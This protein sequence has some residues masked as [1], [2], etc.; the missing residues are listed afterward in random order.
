METVDE[1]FLAA[2]LDFM[3]RK[4][5]A[6]M[7]WFCYFNTTRMHEERGRLQGEVAL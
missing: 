3:D 7:P 1:E 4:T 5:K 6:N 2:A